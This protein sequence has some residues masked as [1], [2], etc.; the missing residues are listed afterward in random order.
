MVFTT[1]IVVFLQHH[2]PRPKVLILPAK[3]SPCFAARFARFAQSHEAPKTA[4]ALNGRAGGP[5]A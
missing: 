1:I 4:V 3:L 2:H 5:S